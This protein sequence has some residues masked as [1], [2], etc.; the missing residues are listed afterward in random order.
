MSVLYAPPLC[1]TPPAHSLPFLCGNLSSNSTCAFIYSC[2]A[3]TSYPSQ[4]ETQGP[5]FAAVWWASRPRSRAAVLSKPNRGLTSEKTPLIGT[6]ERGAVRVCRD[7][8]EVPCTQKWERRRERRGAREAREG[9]RRSWQ[10]SETRSGTYP[11]YALLVRMGN[12][13]GGRGGTADCAR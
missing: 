8:G 3:A 1:L 10:F 9:G 5:G 2:R 12:G 11:F 4:R 6:R 7:E 13:G